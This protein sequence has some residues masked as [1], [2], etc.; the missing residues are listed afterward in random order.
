MSFIIYLYAAGQ[1]CGDGCGAGEAAMKSLEAAQ[2]QME[3]KLKIMTGV[4]DKEL[5]KETVK[6]VCYQNV[7]ENLFPLLKTYSGKTC[8]PN[9][10]S[11]CAMCSTELL[12]SNRGIETKLIINLMILSSGIVG[13][14]NRPI[15]Q[16][17]ENMQKL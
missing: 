9:F 10:H 1:A 13:V 8:F 16:R 11:L 3:Q 12:G 6:E 15:L 4:L 2:V 5:E 14:S 7:F 17:K